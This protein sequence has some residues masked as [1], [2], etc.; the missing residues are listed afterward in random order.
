M[1]RK[2][3]KPK[4]LAA[5]LPSKGERGLKKHAAGKHASARDRI[6]DAIRAIDKAMKAND[7]IYPNSGDG[8]VTI[9]VVLEK[10][11][12]SPAYLE[13]KRRPKI[14]ALKEEV[15]AELKTIGK[16]APADAR[17]I[18]HVASAKAEAARKE[19]LAVRQKYHEAEVEYAATL[20]E[21]AEA[22]SRI[23]ELEQQVGKVVPIGKGRTS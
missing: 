10:A 8:K 22:R 21:L 18:R 2:T 15:K 3:P 20:K 12:L 17:A 16:D 14:V 9:Q 1:S 23:I 11:G 4:S 5:A 6:F 7:G 13:K 19:T